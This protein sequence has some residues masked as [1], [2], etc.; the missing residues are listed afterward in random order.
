MARFELA[1][2]YTPSRCA[3]RLRYIPTERSGGSF[4]IAVQ[5]SQ[6]F[7]QLIAHLPQ[8]GAAAVV[9]RRAVAAGAGGNRRVDPPRELRLQSLLGPGDGEA[10]FV[11]ELFDAQHGVDVAPPIDPLAGAVLRG[12]QRGELRLPVPQDVGL[13]VGDLADLTDLEEELVRDLL[14]VHARLARLSGER[15]EQL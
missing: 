15:T 8:R 6:Y 3:T 13:G 7:A 14:G 1:T 4:T 9:A 2:T 11:E 5:E 12:G 10:L